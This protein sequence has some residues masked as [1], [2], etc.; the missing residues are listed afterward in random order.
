[1]KTRPSNIIAFII[2]F[3]AAGQ[4]SYAEDG[5][6]SLVAHVHGLSELAIAMEGEKL[7]IQFTSPAMNLVGF[8]HQASSRKEVLAIENAVSMLREHETLFLFSGGRCQ[9]VNTSIELSGLIES[10]EHE[11]A[12]QQSSTEHKHDD[13]HKKEH[14]ERPQKNNHSDVV[15]HYQ[16]RCENVAQLSAI[17]VDL[18]EVFHGIHKMNAMWVKS[19]QQGA[20]TLTPN[21]R[22]VEFR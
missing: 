20:A 7:E 3:A 14:K 10:D 21:Q 8:E 17:T 2:A 1:M 22:I 11:H 18:F 9:H 4:F 6:A 15:A 16:Y 13:E 5:A 19:M 12:H